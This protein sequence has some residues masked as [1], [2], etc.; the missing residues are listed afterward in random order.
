MPIPSVPS[1]TQTP[2]NFSELLK[3]Q[4]NFYRTFSNGL[5]NL[6]KV[7]NLNRLRNLSTEKKVDSAKKVTDNLKKGN[8]KK[9]NGKLANAIGFAL[10]LASIGLSL[11]T[12]DHVGKLQGTQLKID[13]IINRDL[14]LAFSRAVNNT[15]S[16]RK[17]R[18][19]LNAFITFYKNE[20]DK[21]FA[22]A[23]SSR[24]SIRGKSRNQA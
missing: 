18:K 24:Q 7:T 2:K 20:K 15:A 4:K 1:Y 21:L 5:T 22:E 10:S 13:G 14:D 3:I 16:L 17:L 8:F 6:T 9:I 19:E 23:Y 12:I 11:L